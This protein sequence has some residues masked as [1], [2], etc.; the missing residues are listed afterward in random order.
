MKFPFIGLY[1]QF[2]Q[3]TIAY[4]A[5]ELLKGMKPTEKC[6]IYSLGVTIWQLE[7]EKSPY[8]NWSSS[9]CLLYHVS[10]KLE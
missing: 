2:F 6:D 10:E 1:F 5:P 4:A 8:E 3:G 9:K 7:Y